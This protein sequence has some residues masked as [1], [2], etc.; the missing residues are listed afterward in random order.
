VQR[1]S[2]RG[3]PERSP[4]SFPHPIERG[5]TTNNLVLSVMLS[6]AGR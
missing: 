4:V 3:H 6:C 2:W 5:S 1:S